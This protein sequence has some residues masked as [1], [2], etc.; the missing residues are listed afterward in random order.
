MQVLVDTCADGNELTERKE[1]M[2]QWGEEMVKG[3]KS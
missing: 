1:R 3:A 2:P